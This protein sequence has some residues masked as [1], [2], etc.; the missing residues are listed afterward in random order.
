MEKEKMVE[1]MY[2]R[3]EKDGMID[4]KIEYFGINA[5]MELPFYDGAKNTDIEDIGLSV[6]S[7]NCLKRAGIDT[8]GKAVVAL[9]QG[10]LL[11]IRNLGLKSRN[12][13][14][15]TVCNFGYENLDERTKKE[16]IRS[17]LKL[18]TLKK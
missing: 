3:M 4:V 11:H 7:F 16:F 18:N 9:R 17:L 1:E 8:V 12:E 5:E 13:I 14:Y 6:R 10:D 2:E 15:V